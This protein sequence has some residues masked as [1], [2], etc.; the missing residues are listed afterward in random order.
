MGKR[1]TISI[2]LISERYRHCTHRGYIEID[3]RWHVRIFL[4]QIPS[5][6]ITACPIASR[7]RWI[8]PYAASY[9][10][11]RI[12]LCIVIIRRIRILTRQTKT[13]RARTGSGNRLILVSWT[14]HTRGDFLQHAASV[15]HV[16]RVVVRS[17]TRRQATH[18]VWL[19]RRATQQVVVPI[20]GIWH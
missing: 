14:R 3:M 19:V 9:D 7:L 20:T 15:P 8:P 10:R 17:M 11:I 18:P 6:I 1:C 16:R 13:V 4:R 5:I 2:V 12:L